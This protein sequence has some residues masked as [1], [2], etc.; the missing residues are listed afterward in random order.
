MTV[1]IDGTTG[2]SLVQDGVIQTADLADGAITAQKIAAGAVTQGITEADQYRMVNIAQITGNFVI[3]NTNG[4]W[5]RNDTSSDKIGTGMTESDGVFTFPSTGIW[6]IMWT[7]YMT[8]HRQ[9]SNRQYSMYFQ[10]SIDGGSNWNDRANATF[11]QND[12]ESAAQA[13]SAYQQY[14]LDVTDTTNFKVRFALGTAGGG[15]L[16]QVLT[17]WGGSSSQNLTTCSFIK[18]GET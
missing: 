11:N 4:V 9:N 14:L 8:D 16:G 7:A 18:L 10:L 6:L 1:T 13:D 3:D 5:E 2:V 17:Q 12:F 15:D